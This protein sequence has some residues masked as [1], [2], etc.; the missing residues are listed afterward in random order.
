MGGRSGGGGRSGRGGGGGGSGG[1]GFVA[2][3]LENG[4]TGQ[5]RSQLEQLRSENIARDRALF[6][7]FRNS[8]DPVLRARIQTERQTLAN[9]RF[10]IDFGTRRAREVRISRGA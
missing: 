9:Q 7:Q 1:I 4:A 5:V 3:G 6:R 8:D 2:A 10:V